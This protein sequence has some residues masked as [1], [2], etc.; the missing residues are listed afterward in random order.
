VENEV[1]IYE[2]DYFNSTLLIGGNDR[3]EAVNAALHL[4]PV[5]ATAP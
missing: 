5:V 4:P 1:P 3:L 2:W